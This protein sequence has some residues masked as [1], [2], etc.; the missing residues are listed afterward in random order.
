LYGDEGGEDGMPQDKKRTKD[1]VDFTWR[2]VPPLSIILVL[3]M[4]GLASKGIYIMWNGISY[5][6]VATVV[7]LA[8]LLTASW[9][10]IERKSLDWGLSDPN[11]NWKQV[12]IPLVFSLWYIWFKSDEIIKVWL[13][14]WMYE[15]NIPKEGEGVV[16]TNSNSE[17]GTMISIVLFGIVCIIFGVFIYCHSETVFVVQQNNVLE[18]IIRDQASVVEGQRRYIEVLLDD[19]RR[20]SND[21]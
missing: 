16:L 13:D 5:T 10:L 9:N 4:R 2:W 17:G 14:E 3:R 15:L 7:P 1:N 20:L 18:S 19:I 12:A 6:S 8:A 21:Q 11:P